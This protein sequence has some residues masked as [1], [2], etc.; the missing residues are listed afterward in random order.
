MP[1]QEHQSSQV[2]SSPDFDSVIT[3]FDELAK[4]LATGAVSRR[5]ALRWMGS[6]LVGAALTAVPGAAWAQV[7]SPAGGSACARFC[8]EIFPPGPEQG[9]CTSQGAQGGGPCYECTPGIDSVT[10]PNFQCPPDQVYDPFAEDGTCCR[11]CGEDAVLCGSGRTADCYSLEF[12]CDRG[13]GGT[14]DPSSCQCICPPG[15]VECFGGGGQP[16]HCV[17]LQSS[18]ESCGQCGHQCVPDVENCVNGVCVPVR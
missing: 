18:R 2:H 4:G 6:A 10:G 1:E 17:D 14:F 7:P 8:R 11:P 16:G 9:Q 5:K 3:S 15:T 13:A 12:D